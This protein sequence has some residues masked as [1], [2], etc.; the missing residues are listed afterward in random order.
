MLKK[1]YFDYIRSFG[2][3]GISRKKGSK[4]NKTADYWAG[5]TAKGR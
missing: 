3:E 5:D 2:P 4:R 1:R